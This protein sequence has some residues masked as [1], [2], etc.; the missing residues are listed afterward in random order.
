MRVFT[1][2]RHLIDNSRE[3]SRALFRQ[4]TSPL[5]ARQ[6]ARLHALSYR[7]SIESLEDRVLLS[8]ESLVPESAEESVVPAQDLAQSISID[9]VQLRVNG[10]N[11]T[12]GS[13]N[14]VVRLHEGDQLEVSGIVFSGNPSANALEGAVAFEGYLR[15]PAEGSPLG[16]FDYAD[17]RFGA[18]GNSDP[19]TGKT[20]Q[21][22][23]LEGGWEIESGWNRLSIPMVRYFGNDVVVEDRFFVNF[24]VEDNRVQIRNANG[25]TFST[26]GSQLTVRGTTLADEIVVQANGGVVEIVDGGNVINT[27][28]SLTSLTSIRVLGNSGDDLLMLDSSLG[29]INGILFGEAGNDELT[30]GDGEDIIIGGIGDDILLG[31]A[32][33]DA[34]SG[35]EGVDAFDGGAGDDRLAIDA[36]DSSIQGGSGRDTADAASASSGINLNM[37][38]AGLEVFFGSAFDDIVTAAGATARVELRGRD[39]S[40]RLTGGDMADLI[41]G[42]SGDDVLVGGGGGDYLIGGDGVDSLSGDIGNDRIDFD[43]SDSSVLGGRGT[44]TGVATSS[45]S[46]VNINMTAA[47]L[48]R[49]IGSDFDDVISAAGSTVGVIVQGRGGND[50]ITGGQGRVDV[51][52]GDDGDDTVDGGDGSDVVIGGAGADSLEAGDGND[53]IDFDENDTKV[54]GGSGTDWGFATKAGGAIHLNM[55]DAGLEIVYGSPFDDI[56]TA[57]GAEVR[58]QINGLDGNDQLTGGNERDVIRGGNG[59]DTL[60]GGPQIDALLGQSGADKFVI[61]GN[62]RTDFRSSEGDTN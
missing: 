15:K 56:I 20:V 51:L 4:F 26:S 41:F 28:I 19:I 7:P 27:G 53:R 49:L 29:E 13:S 24:E 44:D 21:H 45:K 46:G 58:S 22:P 6:H 54:Q 59:N 37:V 8:A 18:P 62:D 34:L 50:Q 3:L 1:F 36:D 31:G 35:L 47:G 23:G 25:V 61:E 48:E 17:G 57:E 2:F 12:V 10:Q 14:D 40:D 60:S 55:V 33:D 16:E 39:G 9:E 43:A 52:S 5:R 11:I 30:G 38:P 32:G 42:E